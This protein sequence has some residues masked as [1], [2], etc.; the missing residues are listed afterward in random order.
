MRAF[1]SWRSQNE[2]Y[3]GQSKRANVGVDGHDWAFFLIWMKVRHC[4]AHGIWEE[5]DERRI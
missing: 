3:D 5:S 1:V 4:D 2:I